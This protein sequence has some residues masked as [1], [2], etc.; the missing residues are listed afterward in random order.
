[1]ASRKIEDLH[2]DLQPICREFMSRCLQDGID[3]IITCTFRSPEE[4]GREYAKGRTVCSNIGVT[5]EKPLGRVVTNAK[6]GQSKHNYIF[7]DGRFA[8]KAFDIVPMRNGRCVWGEQ[9]QDGEIWRH[10]GQIGMALGLD[11]YGAPGSK[12]RELAHFQLKE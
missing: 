6:A 8:A 11:W 7:P 4:Q 3:I 9:G 2:P 10:V 5:P 1:M 12:F